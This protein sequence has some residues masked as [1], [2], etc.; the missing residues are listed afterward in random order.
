MTQQQQYLLKLVKEIDAICKRHG[1]VYWLAGGSLIGALRHGGFLPWDDDADLYMTRANWERFAKACETELPEGRIL[2]S[3]ELDESYTN[4]FPRYTSTEYVTVH[5]HQSLDP[6]FVGEVID[7]FVLDPMKD[8]PATLEAYTHDLMVY[9]D[10]LN[11]SGV[12]GR[13]FEV[14]ARDFIRWRLKEKLH[15]RAWVR[16]AFEQRLAGYLD[17]DGELYV[18]RWGGN[19]FVFERAWFDESE[20]VMFEDVSAWAPCGMDQYLTFQYGYEW[21]EIP[22]NVAAASHDTG[23]S[24]LVEPGAAHEL[25][26]MVRKQRTLPFFLDLRK[27]YMLYRAPKAYAKANR[28]LQLE[29]SLLACDVQAAYAC[30]GQDADEALERLISWQCSRHAA[31]RIDWNGVYRY[32][33]PV[34]VPIDDGIYAAA[35]LRAFCTERTGL[36]ERMLELRAATADGLSD[37]AAELLA[38]VKA[39]RDA[40]LAFQAQ[41]YADASEQARAVFER[42]PSCISACKVMLFALRRAGAAEGYDALVEQAAERFEDDGDIMFLR[43]ECAERQGSHDEAQALFADAMEH[44][45]NGLVLKELATVLEEPEAQ[46]TLAAYR[47]GQRPQEW[48]PQPTLAQQRNAAVYQR[49]FEAAVGLLEQLGLRYT[50]SPSLTF[51]TRHIDECAGFVPTRRSV[52]AL[53]VYPEDLLKLASALDDGSATLPEGVVYEYMGCSPRYHLLNVRIVDENSMDYSTGGDFEHDARGLSI[54]LTPLRPD[55]RGARAK[56]LLARWR[57]TC[58]PRSM[59][60]PGVSGLEGF[61]LFGPV[62]GAGARTRH[63]KR[64]FERV[65]LD[66]CGQ[67]TYW[68]STRKRGVELAGDELE[69]AARLTVL[70]TEVSVAHA[71][72][73]HVEQCETERVLPKL[74]KANDKNISSSYVRYADTP[75]VQ[76]D[77]TYYQRMHRQALGERACRRIRGRFV[78]TYTHDKNIISFLDLLARRDDF[79]GPDGLLMP[80]VSEDDARM[81]IRTIARMQRT[82][83]KNDDLHLNDKQQAFFDEALNAAEIKRAELEALDARSEL[84]DAEDE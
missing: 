40:R 33:H 30:G 29:A 46:E 31:G 49:L 25:C 7:I 80:D 17:D 73:E 38:A 12:Y 32:R 54:A 76:L 11:Y 41:G 67:Q 65:L 62:R 57:R 19:P 20:P 64:V 8:D 72:L 24:M 21:Y 36:A 79:L 1:I 66:A 45:S 35:A 26:A 43:G 75:L 51:F 59:H 60:N 69:H 23:S 28:R 70:G 42:Y 78:H 68:L 34:V 22:S 52:W 74:F 83:E 58:L 27:A 84:G 39:L 50:I 2:Q 13:R 48:A 47:A 15:G 37:E 53:Y 82:L 81:F 55:A 3:P 4:T 9:S 18:M 14:P 61:G 77:S 6:A 5:A 63:G 16:R 71:V 56:A 44:T 10:L